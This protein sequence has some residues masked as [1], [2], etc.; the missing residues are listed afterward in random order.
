MTKIWD[1]DR[2]LDSIGEGHVIERHEGVF[3][4]TVDYHPKHT[5]AI[6]YDRDLDVDQGIGEIAK[7]EIKSRIFDT[8]TLRR[9][10]TK[11]FQP[12]A[13]PDDVWVIPAYPYCRITDGTC[14]EHVGFSPR[15]KAMEVAGICDENLGAC[16]AVIWLDVPT[17]YDEHGIPLN[18]ETILWRCCPEA[19]WP[20]GAKPAKRHKVVSYHN[21]A[22]V[23]F[24]SRP[25]HHPDQLPFDDD[26]VFGYLFN[27]PDEA[28][29]QWSGSA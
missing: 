20:L 27:K 11:A 22:I 5:G 7:L 21:D 17:L 3:K 24:N 18:I 1:K 26:E 15:I 8:R 13:T 10:A 9:E 16:D 25:H 2:W 28:D 12:H 6:F 19:N 23:K 14:I 29:G 4:Q